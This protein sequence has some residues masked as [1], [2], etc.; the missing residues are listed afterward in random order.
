MT[1]RTGTGRGG[2]AL[3]TCAGIVVGILAACTPGADPT[4]SQ[5]APS[6]TS[7]ATV[8]PTQS[9]GPWWNEEQRAFLEQ[10]TAFYLD[11]HERYLLAMATGFAD[12]GNT[13]ALLAAHADQAREALL[14]EQRQ[15]LEDELTFAGKPEIAILGASSLNL[16]D[17]VSGV[18]L[19]VCL[20]WSPVQFTV[21]GEPV[22]QGELGVTQLRESIVR[23]PDGTL[24]LHASEPVDDLDCP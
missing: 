23:A 6:A 2:A 1:R 19:E 4:P 7:T 18:V 21:R 11:L 8:A 3:A 24:R 13:A 12:E 5:P 22:E 15:A 10:A 9:A 20:D 14:T 17:Y 16:T